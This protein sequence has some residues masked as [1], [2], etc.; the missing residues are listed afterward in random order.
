MALLL[1]SCSTED[2][3]MDAPPVIAGAH[4]VGNKACLDC[5]APIVQRF[6]SSPHARV[7]LAGLGQEGDTG[8][9]SCH[10]PG[11]K[12]IAAGGGA[13]FIINPGKDQGRACN[14]IWKFGANSNPRIII[15]SWKAG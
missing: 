5:H 12:H 15:P 3:T 10:G 11:S 8:C 7:H 14:A 9:E 13:K 2:R 6:P 1:D 4:E